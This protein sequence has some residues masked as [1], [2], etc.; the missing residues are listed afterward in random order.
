[1]KG[2]WYANFSVGPQNF[3]VSPLDF[4]CSSATGHAD[5]HATC[6]L[7][8]LVGSRYRELRGNYR[9]GFVQAESDL[10]ADEPG[11]VHPVQWRER[12][13]YRIRIGELHDFHLAS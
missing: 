10:G 2:F 7:P 5:M 13:R 3:S 1:M 12:G 11:R 6:N 9:R 8:K 4:P